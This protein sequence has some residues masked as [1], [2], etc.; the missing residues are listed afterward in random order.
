M[1]RKEQCE[2]G[3]SIGNMVK[4]FR[5]PSF[6]FNLSCLSSPCHFPS[7]KGCRDALSLRLMP[8]SAELIGVTL[9]VGREKVPVCSSSCLSPEIRD[10]GQRGGT[11]CPLSKDSSCGLDPAM[12]SPRERLACV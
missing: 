5:K 8:F 3:G 1:Q 11:T 2:R 9:S 7:A 12:A 6:L 4:K 10:C